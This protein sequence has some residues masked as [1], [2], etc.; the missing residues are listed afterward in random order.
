V[1]MIIFTLYSNI[2]K[3]VRSCKHSVVLLGVNCVE[4]IFG[5]TYF[6]K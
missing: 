2:I 1:K 6:C 3:N 4:I 5:Q